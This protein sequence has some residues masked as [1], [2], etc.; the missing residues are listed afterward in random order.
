MY[1]LFLNL[2]HLVRLILCSKTIFRVKY[3]EIFLCHYHILQ[4]Y[5]FTLKFTAAFLRCNIE[6]ICIFMK[7]FKDKISTEAK[8]YL[9]VL[10]ANC[11]IN[12]IKFYYDLMRDAKFLKLDIKSRSTWIFIGQIPWSCQNGHFVIFFKENNEVITSFY[13]H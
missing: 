11:V 9:K 10:Y 12:V 8:I 4:L 1:Q 7:H 13:H 5:R 2:F 3:W 6:Y